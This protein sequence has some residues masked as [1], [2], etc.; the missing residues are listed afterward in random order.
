MTNSSFKPFKISHLR[1]WSC[2]LMTSSLWVQIPQEFRFLLFIASMNF[3]AQNRKNPKISSYCLWV[4]IWK[5]VT[6]VLF[7]KL[8]TPQ[9]QFLLTKFLA[10][11]HWLCLSFLVLKCSFPFGMSSLFWL[12]IICLWPRTYIYYETRWRVILYWTRHPWLQHFWRRS[13]VM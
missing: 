13:C 5:L 10:D 4:S 9:L 6:I 12:E 1:L 2:G 8:L 7:G 3:L 11:F